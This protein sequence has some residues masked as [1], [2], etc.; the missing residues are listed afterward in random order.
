MNRVVEL[1]VTAGP[2]ADGENEELVVLAVESEV[3][4]EVP[5]VVSWLGLSTVL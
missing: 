5:G 3:P 1:Q 4:P 2:G